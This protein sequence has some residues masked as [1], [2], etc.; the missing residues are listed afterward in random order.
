MTSQQEADIA[1][2]EHRA[3][4]AAHFRDFVTRPTHDQYEALLASLRGVMTYTPA[5]PFGLDH[6]C[7]NP[8]GHEFT[9]IDGDVVCPHCARVA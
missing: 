6:D 1:L 7:D 8:A 3:V 2:A 4:M 5:D 9:A